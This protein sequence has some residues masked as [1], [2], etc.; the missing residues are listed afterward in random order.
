[1]KNISP[2]LRSQVVD[3]LDEK[4]VNDHF[5][6]PLLVDSELELALQQVGD[7]GVGLGGQGLATTPAQCDAGP[8]VVYVLTPVGGAGL[9][10]HRSLAAHVH[11]LCVGADLDSDGV[12][13]PV[14]AHLHREGFNP[15]ALVGI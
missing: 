2:S 14:T 1:M 4:F 10:E 13:G 15:D 5:I 11:V 8:G 12:A 6:L 9:I 3:G 7:G